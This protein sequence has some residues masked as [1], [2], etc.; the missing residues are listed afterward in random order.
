MSHYI[1]FDREVVSTSMASMSESVIASLTVNE[2]FQSH[3]SNMDLHFALQNGGDNNVICSVSNAVRRHWAL[4]TVSKNPKGLLVSSVNQTLG[5][6]VSGALR[7]R[8]KRIKASSYVGLW[9]K[10]VRDS[11]CVHPWT[12]A[13]ALY[14]VEITKSGIDVLKDFAFGELC[15]DWMR[16]FDCF[17]PTSDR[18][19]IG[20]PRSQVEAVA[21]FAVIYTLSDSWEQSIDFSVSTIAATSLANTHG[22]PKLTHLKVMD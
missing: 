6:C 17:V 13:N 20:T 9:E 7:V 14:N 15:L 16:R 19:V 2:G 10:A 21:I 4:T 12:A 3:I 11:K 1:E 8:G 5:H 18:F 22:I